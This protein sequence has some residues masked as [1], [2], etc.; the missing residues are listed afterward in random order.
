MKY[1]LLS[2]CGM[3]ICLTIVSCTDRQKV[4][5]LMIDF[6]KSQIVIPNDLELIYEGKVSKSDLTSLKPNK[7]IIYYDSLDCSSCRISH[8]V[9]NYPLYEMADSCGFSLIT[10][11]SPRANEVEDVRLQLM[12]T[13]SPIP[14]YLDA[15][16]SFRRQNSSIPSDMRF[17]NF[18]VSLD[19]RP[20]FVGNPL[21]SDELYE[22]FKKA[23]IQPN[24]NN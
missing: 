14:I 3:F 22:L 2:L 21:A 7:F 13:H 8:L 12:L 1:R 9:E 17:H 15:N 4:K 19:N 20:S 10:I 5:S 18:L 6:M 16:A 11:F 24:S 23:L